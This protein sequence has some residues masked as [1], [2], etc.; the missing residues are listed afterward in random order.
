[1]ENGIEVT[2]EIR[3]EFKPDYGTPDYEVAD[4]FRLYGS[5]YREIHKI[6]P[7]QRRV[8]QAIENCRTADL[9]GHVDECEACGHLEISYNS[10]RKGAI[11]DIKKRHFKKLL[12]IKWLQF[13]K[14]ENV[15]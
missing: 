10:C 5:G 7:I 11:G 12:D 6:S 13:K 4:I 3:S 15:D 14:R 9:G 1:M 8:M 2:R